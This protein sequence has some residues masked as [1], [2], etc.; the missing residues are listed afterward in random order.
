M[1]DAPETVLRARRL[2]FDRA[3]HGEHVYAGVLPE[4]FVLDG[5]ERVDE[6]GVDAVVGDPPRVAAIGRAGGAERNAVAVLDRHAEAG[7]ARYE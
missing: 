3:A 5:D 7:L 6:V 1:V 4:A 2:A